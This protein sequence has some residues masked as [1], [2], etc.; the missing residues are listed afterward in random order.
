VGGPVV[1]TEKNA[2]WATVHNCPGPGRSCLAPKG[3]NK[4]CFGGTAKRRKRSAAGWTAG[5]RSALIVP[6]KRGNKI[7]QDPVEES[8][9][10]GHG[11]VG[12]TYGGCIEI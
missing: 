4:G 7:R 5:S 11:P 8:E 3:A 10:P 2:V 6:K 1:S 9:T 12:G